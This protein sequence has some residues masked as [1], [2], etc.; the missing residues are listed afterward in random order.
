MGAT[1]L[2]SCF[3]TL[4]IEILLTYTWHDCSRKFHLPTPRMMDVVIYLSIGENNA[5][6]GRDMKFDRWSTIKQTWL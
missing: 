3:P 1:W 2:E 4:I 5:L 6:D